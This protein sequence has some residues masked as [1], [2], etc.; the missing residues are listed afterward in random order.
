MTEL[1]R[2][3]ISMALWL[4]VNDRLNN[5]GMK[6]HVTVARYIEWFKFLGFYAKRE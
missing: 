4:I 1:I 3:E 2:V 5:E 6:K